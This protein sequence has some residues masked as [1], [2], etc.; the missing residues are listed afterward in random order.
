MKG[1]HDN[2]SKLPNIPI[3]MVAS[4]RHQ[5][6]DGT[7]SILIMNEVLYFWAKLDNSLINPNQMRHYG[8]S[9][10]DNPYDMDKT[11][12]I[13]HDQDFIPFESEGATVYFETTYPEMDDIEMHPHLVLTDREVPWDPTDVNM[14]ADRPYGG[15]MDARRH[16]VTTQKGIR[17]AMRPIHRRYRVDHFNLHSNDI[18]GKWQMDWMPSKIRSLA[19]NVG[20]FVISNGSFTEVYPQPNHKSISAAESLRRFCDDVWGTDQLQ[21]GTDQLQDRLSQGNHFKKLVK[22]RHIN[23]T[24]TEPER[25]SQITRVD[26]KIH[27]LKRRW[28]DKMRKKNVPERLWDFGLVYTGKIMQIL[29]K[30]KLQDMM[31]LEAVVTGKTPNISEFCDFDCYDLLWYHPGV[32]PSISQQNRDVGRWLGVSEHVG[33]DM[34]YWILG[35]NGMG[36]L[37]RHGDVAHHRPEW[38]ARGQGSL[39][40]D[41]G[42]FEDG[43]HDHLMANKIAENLYAQVDD[44]ARE[45]LRFADIIDHRK[46]LTALTKE[47]GF[48]KVKGGGSKCIKTT[49]GWELL[50]EWK[51]GTSSWLP[52]RDAKEASPYRAGRVRRDHGPGQRAH[53]RVAGRLRAEEAVSDHQEAKSKYWCTTQKYGIYVPKTLEKALRIDKDKGTDFWE[54]AM[55]KEMT[56]AKVSYELVDRCMPEEVRLDKVPALRGHQEIS[57]HI[58]FDV[59]MDFMRKVC[60]VENGSTTNTPSALTYLIVVSLDS[61]GIALLLAALNDLDIFACDKRNAY[62]KAPCKKLIWFVAGHKCGHKMKGHVMKL[63]HA[64]YGLKSSG[65]SWRKMFKDVI[66]THLKFIPSR[67]DRDMYYRRNSKP[68]GTPYYELPS[69]TLTMCLRLATTPRR[70]WR[71]SGSVS[72]SRMTTMARQHNLPGWRGG[73]FHDPKIQ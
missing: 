66:E 28:H 32:H 14:N 23:M 9:V 30:L 40:P 34:C 43:T 15:P 52:L 70:S 38:E 8:I 1:F 6:K 68:D 59:K 53:L 63:V 69:Y 65:A 50:V 60:F 62:L 31:A 17:T 25:K 57:C 4:T 35:N 51:D 10:S 19:Q 67:V 24:Y 56:K 7:E 46:D 44:E 26:R 2:F 61:V 22:K 45:I 37:I 12:G 73:T 29:P 11:L 58:S 55:A 20:A 39:Q 13:D 64:L 33:S 49:K 41:A 3:A 21:D 36:W 71:Q 47:N 27:D 16:A 18:G 42:H 48:I 5:G 72:R 54:K